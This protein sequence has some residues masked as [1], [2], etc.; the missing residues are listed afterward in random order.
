VCAYAPKEDGLIRRLAAIAAALILTM[1]VAAP[2]FA[3]DLANGANVP[4]NSSAYPPDNASDCDGVQAG[5]VLFHFV[6]TGTGPTEFA[7]NPT[8]TAIFTSAGSVTVNAY[9]PGNGNVMYDVT[10]ASPDTLISASDTI[11]DDNKLNL[12]HI[13]DGG[14]PPDVPEAP[15]SVLLL[16]TAALVVSGFVVLRMRGSRASA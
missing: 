1:L 11:V 13:C 12:S 5:T 3:N 10:V 7:T 15:A 4:S 6:H 16:V 8:L 2:A 9:E 14:P